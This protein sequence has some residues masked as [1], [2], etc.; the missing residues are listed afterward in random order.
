[1]QVDLTTRRYVSKTKHD[2]TVLAFW[3]ATLAAMEGMGRGKARFT[4]A[5]DD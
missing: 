1:M 4:A 3:I 2:D 5:W